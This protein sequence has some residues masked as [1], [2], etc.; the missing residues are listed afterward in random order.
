MDLITIFLL[1]IGLSM[2]SMAVAISSGASIKGH[3]SIHALEIGGFF[4]AFQ[5]IMPVAGWLLGKS[6]SY[7]ISGIDHWIAFGLL[8]VIGAKMIYEALNE[9]ASD[10]HDSLDLKVVLLLSIATS[11][12]ALAVGI[13][14]SLLDTPIVFPAAIIGVVCFVLSSAGV[15]IS[16]R[17]TAVFGNRL[18]IIGGVILIAIGLKILV[19]HLV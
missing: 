16:S 15:A 1:A 19:E 2:D 3:R 12:D 10:G 11:I 17:L 5:A 4:G 9:A 7:L 8:L 6:F 13:S 14:I 18:K